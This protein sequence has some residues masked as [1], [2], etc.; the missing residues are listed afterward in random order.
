MSAA[1][2]K[3][4]DAPAHERVSRAQADAD[5]RAVNERRLAQLRSAAPC[6]RCRFHVASAPIAAPCIYADDHADD[7]KRFARL[8]QLFP[9]SAAAA[10]AAAPQPARAVSTP[11]LTATSGVGLGVAAS[12]RAL[13][14]RAA[15][16]STSTPQLVQQ[17]AAVPHHIRPSASLPLFATAATAAGSP[18]G[19]RT[20]S[21]EQQAPVVPAFDLAALPAAVRLALT[22]ARAEPAC[23]ECGWQAAPLRPVHERCEHV[24]AHRRAWRRLQWLTEVATRASAAGSASTA[25]DDV[26]AIPESKAERVEQLMRMHAADAC[27]ECEFRPSRGGPA[28]QCANALE[29]SAARAKYEWLV[30]NVL[31]MSVRLTTNIGNFDIDVRPLASVADVRQQLTSHTNRVV[32]AVAADDR[33]GS[34]TAELLSLLRCKAELSVRFGDFIPIPV[35]APVDCSRCRRKNAAEA[36]FCVHC[37]TLLP[38]HMLKSRFAE[39]TDDDADELEDCTFCQNDVTTGAVVTVLPCLHVF[40]H[41]CIVSWLRVHSFCP[42]CKLELTSENLSIQ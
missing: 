18:G 27:G 15:P 3:C 37:K 39:P 9:E 32:V 41:D 29:H 4:A 19:M 38:E 6:A 8:L 10:A 11:G 13:A 23:D 21:S 35:D 33:V 30:Q 22:K 40:H 17:Q 25:A 2:R 28:K 14:G 12:A 34:D 36:L 5:E 16:G 31:M 20:N 26:Y 1:H 42:N 24:A 7:A